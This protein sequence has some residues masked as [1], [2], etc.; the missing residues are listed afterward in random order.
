MRDYSI[1][2]VCTGNICRSPMAEGLL[3]YLFPEKFQEK[4]IISSAGTDALH[5][6]LATDFAIRA[7]QEYG[8]DISSHRARR[9]TRQMISEADLIL[10]MEKYH[11]KIVRSLKRF[12]SSKIF[13]MSAF[14]NFRAPYEIPDPIGDDLNLYRESARLIHNCLQGV[15]CY[16][17]EQY[18]N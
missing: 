14:D 10:V 4:A 12:T 3:R 18:E 8:V 11:L 16:I 15:Y 2:V 5:G 13:L 17:E 7:M 1:L 6:N 9:L